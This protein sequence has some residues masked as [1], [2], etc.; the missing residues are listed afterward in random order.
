MRLGE[1]RSSVRSDEHG[2]EMR[3][4][5][6]GRRPSG[7]AARARRAARGGPRRRSGWRTPGSTAPVVVQLALPAARETWDA[8]SGAGLRRS[9][10]ASASRSAVRTGLAER[11]R[12]ERDRP[13]GRSGSV[14]RP[15]TVGTGASG[16]VPAT[17]TGASTATAV[18]SGI[19]TAERE[20]P[21]TGNAVRLG[22][23][24]RPGNARRLERPGSGA[25][26]RAR[27]PAER[28][29]PTDRERPRARNAPSVT[30]GWS[31]R[32]AARARR[33][34]ACR[35]HDGHGARRPADAR[36]AGWY[37]EATTRTTASRSGA[38]TAATG[39]SPARGSSDRDLHEHTARSTTGARSRT[40]ARTTA[41]PGT[42]WVEPGV[43]AT[44]SGDPAPAPP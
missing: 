20:R 43:T 11:E 19:G 22:A 29:R 34:R 41:G 38:A 4:E 14:A 25:A 8:F 17:G 1:R 42:D 24:G 2:T 9:G 27:T 28:E 35:S 6:R 32:H 7:G 39:P 30:R 23:P 26:R 36:A 13:S 3:V 44:A 16:T 37:S 33:A 18:A 12:A 31:G 40:G 5:D 15:H 21:A 10:T